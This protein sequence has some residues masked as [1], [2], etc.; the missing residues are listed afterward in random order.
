MTTAGLSVFTLIRVYACLKVF[1]ELVALVAGAQGP[2]G[3]V[4]TAMR[5]ATVV[6]LTA[7]HNLH[8]YSVALFSISTQFKSRVTHTAERSRYVHTAM[9]ALSLTGHTFINVFTSPEVICQCESCSAAALNQSIH[10]SADLRTP[11]VMIFT[12]VLQFTVLSVSLELV[13]ASTFTLVL[14][15]SQIHTLVFTSAILH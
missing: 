9:S 6:F 4:F 10:I 1:S 8:L 11:A 15:V 5:A 2:A 12:G 3:G 13:V 14:F 7:V